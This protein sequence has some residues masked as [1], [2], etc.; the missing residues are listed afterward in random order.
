LDDQQKQEEEVEHEVDLEPTILVIK[1]RIG[2]CK[3][4]HFE[5]TTLTTIQKQGE[6]NEKEVQLEPIVVVNVKKQ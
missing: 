4:I 2:R 3:R 1:A 5:P 6:G